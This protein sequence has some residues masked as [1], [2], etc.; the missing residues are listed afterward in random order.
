MHVNNEAETPLS[1]ADLL[2]ENNSKMDDGSLS[3]YADH[4]IN[5]YINS[6]AIT[7]SGAAGTEGPAFSKTLDVALR[8]IKMPPKMCKRGSPIGADK[9]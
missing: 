8:D 3:Y 1:L 7:A 6:A 5:A 2:I 9:P 4:T